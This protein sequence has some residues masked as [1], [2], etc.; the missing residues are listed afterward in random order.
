[1]STTN[2]TPAGTLSP[3]P[4]ASVP[5]TPPQ[6]NPAAG[7]GALP[8]RREADLLQLAKAGWTR[9]EIAAKWGT[10]LDNVSFLAC[11]ARK[12]G[13][14]IPV[15]RKE[16]PKRFDRMEAWRMARAGVS[17]VA[18]GKHFGVRATSVTAALR[19]FVPDGEVIPTRLP[20]RLNLP[21]GMKRLY[22]N[23]RHKK[24]FSRDEAVTECRRVAAQKAAH[25]LAQA[26]KLTGPRCMSCGAEPTPEEKRRFFLCYRCKTSDAASLPNGFV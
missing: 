14:R 18:I 3:R 15:L 20:P 2:Q 25:D 21:E 4:V 6:A 8:T 10:G 13:I 11:K 12:R 17:H 9:S 16:L 19:R 5:V 24:G 1:M 22:E 7:T 26:P 23:L